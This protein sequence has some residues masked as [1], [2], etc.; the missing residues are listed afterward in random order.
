MSAATRSRPARVSLNSGDTGGI[1][2]RRRR[3]TVG[4]GSEDEYFTFARDQARLDFASHQGNDFQ[5]DDA[6]WAHL[7]RTVRQ[8]QE[9]GRFVVFPRVRV[10]GEY[11]RR[12]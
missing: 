9:D 5:I 2:T 6:Y 4:T 3:A 8:F 11:A 12:R 7:N 10:V 1:S